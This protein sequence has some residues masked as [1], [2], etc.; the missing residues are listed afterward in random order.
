MELIETPVFTRQVLAALSDEEYRALQLHLV[1][2]P[3]AGVLIPGSGGLRKLRWRLPGRGK[4][5]G[6]RVIYY[7]KSAVGQLFLL[8]LYPKNV[9]SDLSA[10]ELRVLRQFVT[11]N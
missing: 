7:W 8:F 9:R 5:S 10:T 2:R 3:D 6:A 4:R 11:G 1:G